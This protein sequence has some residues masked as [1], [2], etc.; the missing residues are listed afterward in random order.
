MPALA[1]AS[2]VRRAHP[3]WRV[4]LVGAERGVEARILPTRD[5]PFELL[6]AEPIYRRQWWKNLRW[7]LLA[8]R[9][10]RQVDRLLDR[11]QPSVVVGTGGYAAGPVVWRAARRGIPTALQE[12]NAYPGIATRWLAR[13][14]R[15]IWLGIPETRRH[16]KPGRDTTV[17]DLGTPIVPP[18]PTRKASAL[19]RFGLDPA[20]P[21]LLVTGGSQG[22]LAVNEAVARWLDAGGG[23]G[24]QILWTTGRTTYDRFRSRHSPP[25]V[26]VFDFLDPMADAYAVASLAISRSGML[27]VAELAAWGIPAILVPLPTAAADHQTANARVMADAGAAIHLPQAEFSQALIGGHLISGL[28]ESPTRLEEMAAAA[29]SRGRPNAAAEISARIGILSG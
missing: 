21:V 8:V 16:L 9:L 25:S 18:D 10:A 3:D 20:R 4:V 22:A 17:L 6:P 15:E 19:Q 24:L 27:T 12:Q 13:R 1:I 23:N 26:Q 29:R 5:F 2:E 7:P 28:L 14:V 11:E